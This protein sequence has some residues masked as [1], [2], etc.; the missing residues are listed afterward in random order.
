[1]PRVATSTA[2]PEVDEAYGW[3]LPPEQRRPE[4][5]LVA[6]PARRRRRTALDVAWVALALLGLAVAAIAAVWYV[7]LPGG[8]P[9]VL[10]VP[11]VVGLS[12][13]AAVHELTT[14]GFTVRAIEQPA[15]ASAGIVFAQRPAVRTRL[16]RGD[17][18]T[19]SVAN[20][21]TARTVTGR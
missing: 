11:R 12:E 7:R 18:V 21:Q 8:G 16:A 1:V 20:G 15:D 19:I 3:P 14:E 13:A 2:E 6:V 10:S 9:S 5:R 4:A 17:V